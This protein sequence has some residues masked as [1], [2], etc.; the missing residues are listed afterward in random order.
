MTIRFLFAILITALPLAAN[1]NPCDDGGIGGTGKPLER[2]IGGTG[3]TQSGIGGTGNSSD[4]LK[5]IA[6]TGISGASRGIGGTGIIQKGIGGTGQEAEGGIGGTGVVGVIT[7]FGSICVNGLEV[8]F[9]TDTPIDSDGK[10]LSSEALN[11][12]QMVAVRATGNENGLYAH[13]IH[14][15]HQ[16]SGPITAI[17]VKTNRLKVMGQTIST[18]ASQLSGMQVGKWVS[19][20]GLNKSDGTLM[21]TRIDPSNAQVNVQVIGPLEQK[22]KNYYIN[23]TK[24]EGIKKTNSD[25]AKDVRVTG[26]W[27]GSAVNV[28]DLAMG[29]VSHLLQKVDK[30]YMQGYMSNGLAN[31][32][33]M[34]NG[35]PLKITGNTQIKGNNTNTYQTNTPIVVHGQIKEGKSTAITISPRE[36]SIHEKSI[37]RSHENDSKASQDGIKPA[38]NKET[39]TPT[40]ELENHPSNRKDELHDKIKNDVEIEKANKVEKYEKV[41]T[42]EKVERIEKVEVPEKI[43]RVEKIE[44]PERIERVEKIE[45]PE[46]IER[47]EKVERSETY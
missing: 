42:I 22:G 9:Y 4:S 16:I 29:P 13:E 33:I 27:D 23:G 20:S 38:N 12:G 45:A 39:A 14:V 43:E 17:D 2:G 47:V 6:G 1:A 18:S 30:F 8:H 10:R 32:R 26:I 36:I 28:R 40:K 35:Q 3:I 25:I 7:G 5:G 44:V 19:V 31:G 41:E 21:A 37:E 46:K 15:Y 11:I 34:L 24:I